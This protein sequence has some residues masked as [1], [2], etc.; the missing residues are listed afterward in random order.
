MYL[1]RLDAD[2]LAELATRY[3]LEPI[4]MPTDQQILRVVGPRAP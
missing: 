1:I 2:E 3:Q 4:N